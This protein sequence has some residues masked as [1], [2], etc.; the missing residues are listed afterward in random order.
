METQDRRP[1]QPECERCGRC[2]QVCPSYRNQGIETFSPR[3]RLDLIRA[4][5]C[6]ELL[7]G[8]RYRE[9][10][11]TC[12]QCL[13]C[14]RACPKGVNGAETIREEKAR[15]ISGSPGFMN[16]VERMILKLILT[17][18]H[19]LYAVTAVLSRL[20]RILKMHQGPQVRHL[21]LFLPELLSGRRIPL[22][23]TTPVFSGFPELTGPSPGTRIRGRVLLYT[24]CFFGYADTKPAAAAMKVLHEN[25]YQ[26]R[27]P[28]NQTC[29]GA[30]A[31]LGGYPDIARQTAETNLVALAGNDPVITLCA[32]CGNCLKN[33]YPNLFTSDDR[34][35]SRALDLSGRIVDIHQFLAGQTSITLGSS[36]VE[37]RVTIHDPCHLNRGLGVSAEV[38]T[39]LKQ[40]PGLDIHEMDQADACCGGGGLCALHNPDLSQKLGSAKAES[41]IQSDSSMAASPCPGC[42][43][44]I[45]DCLSR[46]Q[47]SINAVHPVELLAAT[48][49]KN[50]N[51][52]P[53]LP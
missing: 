21:P 46:K 26:V 29:C 23:S 19:A 43:L 27:I 45:N 22:L 28:G 1:D 36:A 3:G 13:A 40:V 4:M 37:Q 11:E 14:F 2:L 31:L 52:D 33:D 8:P 24:G 20:Q 38:R 48:F 16:R 42:L 10:M 50:N 39:L 7:P 9:S 53:L 35:R 5:A 32:T 15:M 17:N 30:P 51:P 6:H 18:R 25:G 49:D 44:Q 34:N 41:I 12:L 47:S